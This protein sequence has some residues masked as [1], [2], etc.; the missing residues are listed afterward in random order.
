MSLTTAERTEWMFQWE[1]GMTLEV[2]LTPTIVAYIHINSVEQSSGIAWV[3]GA[4]GG[5]QFRRTMPDDPLTVKAK[6]G[7]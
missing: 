3:I 5:L 6:T 4:R 7:I 1:T 2:I